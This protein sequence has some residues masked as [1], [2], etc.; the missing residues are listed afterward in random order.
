MEVVLVPVHQ[1]N[2]AYLLIDKAS[3]VAAAV[4]PAEPAKVLAAAN[5]RNLNI[6]TILT[7]HHHWCERDRAGMQQLSCIARC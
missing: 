7:T 1:D 4:D 5:E 6:T 3:N 2:Y